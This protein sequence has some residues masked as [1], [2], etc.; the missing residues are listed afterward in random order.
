[1]RNYEEEKA[2]QLLEAQMNS[3][4]ERGAWVQTPSLKKLTDPLLEEIGR[5]EGIGI[6]TRGTRR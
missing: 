1:M 5:G 2:G 4:N 3:V 6:K